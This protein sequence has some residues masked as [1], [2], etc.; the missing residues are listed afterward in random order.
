[1]PDKPIVTFTWSPTGSAL[2]Y[3]AGGNTYP[4]TH[5]ADLTTRAS[6]AN[7]GAF[8]TPINTSITFTAT[9]IVPPGIFV[10]EYKWDLGDGTIGYG[11]SIAH[12]YIAAVSQM[13]ATVTITD[14]LRRTA[15]AS[16]VLNLRQ[17]KP[18]LV[19]YS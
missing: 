18:I 17:A 1:M 9:A 13:A 19:R 3:Q 2:T 8:V 12:T 7:Y 6:D 11:P 15:N 16:Q 14:S 10:S 5:Q 4:Y